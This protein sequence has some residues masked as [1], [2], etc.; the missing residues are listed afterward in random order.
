MV[1][2]FIYLIISAIAYSCTVAGEKQSLEIDENSIDAY[3]N[4][5]LDTS[6]TYDILTGMR[7]SKGEGYAYSA[8]R[9][10]QNDT[11]ILYTELIEDTT[12]LT[13]RNLFFKENLP[14]FV[15][16][17]IIRTENNATIFIQRKIY[18]NGAIILKAL[19]RSASSE[20]ELEQVAFK[21]ITMTMGQFDFE[22]AEQAVTQSGDYEMQFGEFLILDPVSYLILENE[23]SGYSVA[24]YLLQGDA[25]INTLYENQDAYQGKTIRA[26][27]EFMFIGG[28]EQ[29]V[30]A[31]GDVVE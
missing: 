10:S 27:H 15:E 4:E 20:E 21:E 7:F 11:A 2:F 26:Y 22:R 6:E 29:M 9:F 18:L 3:V 8:V 19:E 31:G 5:K 17:N 28:M 23:E 30:Y 12:G 24:L 25:L 14:V 16:E 1:R 13:Y